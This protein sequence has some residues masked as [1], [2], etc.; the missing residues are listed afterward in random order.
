MG[1]E[2]AVKEFIEWFAPYLYADGKVPCCVDTRGSDP[3]PENDSN[4]EF[5]YLVA[6]YFRYTGDRALAER[7][8]PAVSRSAA[9]LDSMRQTHRTAEWRSKPEFFGLL[10]PSISHEGYSAKPMHSYWDDLFALRGFKDAAYLAAALGRGDEAKRWGAA[11]DEFQ[12]ELVASMNAAMAAHKIDYIPGAADLGDFDATSTTI[13]LEPVQAENALPRAALEQTFQRYYQFFRDRRT[14]KKTWDAFTPY[15]IRN[16][17]AFVRLGWRERAQELNDWFLRY[18]KPIGWRQW[19]E[20]VWN[21]ERKPHFIGD[22]PHTWVGSDYVRSILDCFAYDRERDSTLVLAAGVPWTWVSQGQG[23]K[24]GDL[25]TPYGLLSYT[26]SA[27]GG[28]ADLHV[29]EGVRVP[30]GGLVVRAPS[31]LKTFHS[32][33]VNG[34]SVTIGAGGEVVVREVPADVIL[35]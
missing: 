32:A 14:G 16:I 26:L 35:R 1:H 11:R 19:P 5:I 31:P 17:G 28:G 30:P 4:G 6:E 9:Y 15:E 22:L 24:I 21:D 3:V 8:W 18:R 25:R 13:A 27:R 2:G 33:T 7:M 23:V 20:V 12:S 29:A 34:K 10:P